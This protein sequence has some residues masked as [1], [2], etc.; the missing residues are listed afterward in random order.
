[1][2]YRGNPRLTI[3]WIFNPTKIKGIRVCLYHLTLPILRVA[4]SLRA[5]SLR[6]WERKGE[7]EPLQF[8]L[9]AVLCSP[10]KIPKDTVTDFL[11]INQH[12]AKHVT[13]HKA[14]LGSNQVIRRLCQVATQKPPLI[15]SWTCESWHGTTSSYSLSA[16]NIKELRAKILMYIPTNL[17]HCHKSTT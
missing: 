9:C 10:V 1:M 15:L 2:E 16:Y 4:R 7:R 11:F 14:S 17:I 8:V 13:Q 12:Y 5:R 6:G 3:E